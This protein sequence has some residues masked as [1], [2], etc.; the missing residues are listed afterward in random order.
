LAENVIAMIVLPRLSEP[1]EAALGIDA[2]LAPDFL[3]DTSA[4][5]EGVRNAALSSRNQLPPLVEI[6]LVVIDE[7]SARRFE[8]G[9]TVPDYAVDDLFERD[10]ANWSEQLA[11]LEERLSDLGVSYEILPVTVAVTGSKWSLQ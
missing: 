6:R 8:N 3:Y 4:D 11:T 1:D 10:A 7:A 5:G 2:G 9:S